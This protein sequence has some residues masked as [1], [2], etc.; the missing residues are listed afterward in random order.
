MHAASQIGVRSALIPGL[1]NAVINGAIAYQGFKGAAL[2]PLTVDVSN[3]G[4]MTVWSEVV[5]LS[6]SLSAILGVITAVLF[7]KSA[8]VTPRKPVFPTLVLLALEQAVMLFGASVIF[9]LLWHRLAGTVLVSPLAAALFV[10]A[11]AAVITIIVDIRVKRAVL[12]K[13]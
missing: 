2:I 8:G 3:G 6:F 1:I 4:E 11:A 7:Q 9:A 10:A 12:R 5:A 13:D